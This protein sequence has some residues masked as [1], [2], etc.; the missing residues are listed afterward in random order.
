MIKLDRYHAFQQS[1]EL[2]K[3]SVQSFDFKSCPNSD[4]ADAIADFIQTMTD[5]L[6][7]IDDGSN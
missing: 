6:V 3:L 2:A 7:D 5:R 1:L 4:Y